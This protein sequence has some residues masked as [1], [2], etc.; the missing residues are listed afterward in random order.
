MRLLKRQNDI[1][2]EGIMTKETGAIM[3]F[4]KRHNDKRTE[5]RMT[6]ETRGVMAKE[7][8][9]R[10]YRTCALNFYYITV[11]KTPLRKPKN[12]LFE[13]LCN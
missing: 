7:R 9:V 13:R 2:T 4:L 10:E 8:R 12:S 6:K 1:M 11:A 3:C 5:S